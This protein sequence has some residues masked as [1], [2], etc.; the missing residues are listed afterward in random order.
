MQ[1]AFQQ[2][3]SHTNTSWLMYSIPRARLMRIYFGLVMD[4]FSSGHGLVMLWYHQSKACLR[5]VF[6]QFEVEAHELDI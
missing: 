6:D 4:W 3:K 2:N 5:A 1:T